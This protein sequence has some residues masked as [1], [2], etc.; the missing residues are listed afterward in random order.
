MTKNAF[1]RVLGSKNGSKNNFL[2]F[3]RVTFLRDHKNLLFTNFQAIL[4]IFRRFSWKLPIF[5]LKNRKKMAKN[6]FFRVLGSKNGYKNNFLKFSRVT[7]LRD[8]ANLLFTNFQAILMKISN[9][10]N[11]FV[12]KNF[13]ILVILAKK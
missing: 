10:I 1:F 2:K 7:F 13:S 3:S 5:Y 11:F 8:H 12:K 9:F 6:A 4:P